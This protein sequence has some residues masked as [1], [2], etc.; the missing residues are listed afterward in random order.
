MTF[1]NVGMKKTS[2]GLAVLAI[3][4]VGCN[5]ATN[6]TG[7]LQISTRPALTL[8]SGEAE[9]CDQA[10]FGPVVVGHGGDRITFTSVDTGAAVPLVWPHG[11]AARL[12][13][14]KAELMDSVGAVIARE[15]DT[16]SDLGGGGD[17][18]CSIGLH[19]YSDQFPGIANP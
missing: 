5:R 7:A 15:G 12:V 13:G 19:M 8:A 9:A 14:D 18:V 17:Q 10:H 2:L 6:L 1:G 16:L 3:V 4:A 11:F